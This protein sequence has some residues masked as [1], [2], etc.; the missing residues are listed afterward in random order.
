VTSQPVEANVVLTADNS[1]YDQAMTSSAQSTSSLGASIDTLGR[2]INSLTKTAGKTLIGISAAD[3]G[4]ITGAVAAWSSYEKQVS[5]LNAQS[6]ILTR[7]QDAQSRVMKDY[8]GAVKGLRT[9]YGTTTAEAAKL[10]ETLSKI[11]SVRQS[12]D[13]QDLSKVFVDMSHATGESSEGLAQSLTNLQ[14]VM[15]TPINEQQSRRYAD[16]FTYLAA[17]TNIS[18]QGLMD[19]TAQLAPVAKSLGMNTREVAGFATAFTQAGQEGGAAATAFTK[20]TGDM[21][22]SLQ[23]GSPELATYANIVGMTSRQFREL[24]KDDSTEAV[25][26]VFE[27]LSNNTRTAT[28]DLNRLGLDGPRTFRAITA[29]TNQPGGIRAA[30]G[31]AEDPRAHGAAERGGE[32]AMKGLSDEFA[33]L[34]EEMKLTAESMATILGPAVEGFMNGMVKAS[35]VMRQI[36]EGPMGEFLQMIMAVVAPLAGGAGA[37]LLFAGTLLKVAAAFAVVRNSAALGIREGFRGGAPIGR[38]PEGEYIAAGGG[39]LGTRGQQLAESGTWFQRGLYNIGVTGGGLLG[40]GREAVR[41]SWMAGRSWANPNYQPGPRRGPL[42]YLAGGI[43]RGVEFITPQ[44]DQMRYADPTRRSQWLQQQAPWSRMAQRINLG[45][46]MGE[47]GAAE[48]ELRRI[49]ESEA[50]VRA[51]PGISDVTRQASLDQLKASREETKIRLD[52]AR[53]AERATREEILARQTNTRE[54][55]NS[56]AGFRRLG[57]ATAGFAVGAGGA[58]MGGARWGLGAMMRS[59][60]GLPIAGT[61]GA[62]GMSAVGVQSNALMFGALGASMGPYGAAGGLLLGAGVDMAQ[63]NNDVGDSIKYLN[64][65]ATE[66]SKSGT[67]LAALDE[68]SVSATKD[69]EDLKHSFS[70][71]SKEYWLSPSAGLGSVKN[72]VEGLLWGD[73]DVEELQSDLGKAQESFKDT[74]GTIR[75]LAKATGIEVGGTRRTQLKQLEEF[76]STTG[77]AKLEAAG[78][79]LEDLVAARREGGPTYRSLIRRVRQ[80]EMT[81]GLQER[82]R[83][84]AAGEAMLESPAARRS[85]RFEGDVAAFYKA[86]NE[87]FTNMREQGMSYLGILRSSERAQQRIGDEN[88][89]SYELQMA[90][91]QKA[92][93]ALQMQAPQLGRVGAFQQQIQVGQTLMGIRPRTEEQAAQL[94]QQ[95]Q[96]T[97][98]SFADMDQYFRQMLLAQEQFDRQRSRMEQDYALQRSYQEQDYQLQRTR[99]EEQFNRMRA[100]ATADYARNT[101]RAWFDFH[102]QRQRQEEDFRHQTQITANQQAIQMANVWQR[103]ETQRTSSV[104]WM[105]ANFGDQITRMQQQATNLDKVRRMGLS[106]AAIQQLQLSSPE[107]AQQLE[108]TVT[109][110][111]P[112]MVRRLNRQARQVRGAAR[113]LVTDPSDMG[114][115]E[116]LRGFR[117]GRQRASEDMERQMGRSR[118]DFRRGLREQRTDFNIMMDQQAEDYDTSMRRQEKQYKTT[119]DRAAEDMAHMADEITGSLTDVLIQASEDLTGSAQKQARQV[120]RSFKDL[121]RDTRPEAVALMRELANVFGFDYTAPKKVTTPQEQAVQTRIGK[122]QDIMT[123]RYHAGGMVPGYSPDRDNQTVAVSGGEAIMRPEWAK[124]VGKQNIDAM[125]HQARHGGFWLGGTLPL[126]GASTISQHTSG[127]PFAVWAGD[128]NWPGREDYGKPIVAWKAGV[129]HPFDYGRDYSYGRGQK[130]STEGGGTQL[131]AHMSKVLTGLAGKEVRAGEVIG[132]VGDYGNTGSP[133]T[134]HLHFEVRDGDVNLGDAEG[135]GA[136]GA[137]RSARSVIRS[138]LKDRYPDSEAAARAMTGVHPLFPGDISSIINRYARARIRQLA[139]R[140]PGRGAGPGSGEVA[141]R[142]EDLTGNQ[143]LVRRAMI[144]AGWKGQWPSLYQLVM[145]ESGFNN[146][147][148]NPTSTAYGMFQFLDGTWSGTGIAKTSDPWKQAVAGMRYIGGK[149]GDPK[150]AWDFWQANHWYR[151]G[152]VFTSPKTIGVGEGGPEAVI[153]LNERGGEF[154][155]QVLARSVGMGGTPVRGGMSVYNTRIDRSTNFTGPITVQANDP[156]ELISKLQSRQRVMALTRPSLT[157]SAA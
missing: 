89:R 136:R 86:T 81:P 115:Q 30:L 26:R 83:T 97:V 126:P 79:D 80:G 67:G 55:G 78:V 3:V 16:T 61:L 48:S 32:A 65:Q 139:R 155:S 4:L 37:L 8:A 110:L 146:T 106:D 132:Y 29:L 21:L 117:L 39:R 151:D 63:A 20:V 44:F 120:L 147:A 121:R 10:V 103:I 108:R 116:T 11:T 51:Q 85:M 113:E 77:M 94:E 49:R 123:D 144:D 9:E 18:A 75:D 2:K 53:S 22:K 124:A 25:V 84:T 128:L 130:I 154:M 64:E 74:E 99:A 122:Q 5:R 56:T 134:S 47:V 42:S 72:S 114:W 153:P 31:L 150:G 111:T 145:H 112:A 157:G 142:P 57:Q 129:A 109:E 35:E 24:A 76:M 54:V 95:K 104:E 100:R 43:G 15:G 88:N 125:N 105:S 60:M 73:S 58:A 33:E 45:Q 62:A 46:Q 96:L 70:I 140:Y 14:K 90:I 40:G 28:A 23:S 13:L 101:S 7:T 137:G 87:V 71:T 34:R 149:Y 6:A 138:L 107:M 127:Y 19:F 135:G 36:A 143:E 52:S 98:Q 12:R 118:R 17:Q 93:Y 119:M 102:L 148:Q 38:T 131:Y 91:A 50:A 27:A 59:P 133:P 141:P 156:H 92:Q 1:Q 66:A 41:E 152:S 69:F 68:A 82:L